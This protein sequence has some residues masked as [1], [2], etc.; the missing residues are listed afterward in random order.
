MLAL[1]AALPVLAAPPPSPP[2]LIVAISVDQFA[3]ALFRHYR[4]AY[5]GGLARLAGGIGFTGYQ[6]H[7]ATETCPGHST[8][9]TGDHPAHTG[10]VANEWFD[11]ATGSSIYCVSVPGTAD[12]GARGGQYLKVDTLGD[13]LKRARPGARVIAVSGKDRAAIMM[14][15]HH[16]DAIYWW[17]DRAGFTT[18]RY[19]APATP[20]VMEPARTFDTALFA[21][22]RA[23]PPALWPAEVPAR[24]VA[25][26]HPQSF[27]TLT[28]SGHVPPDGAKGIEAGDFLHSADFADQLRASPLFDAET[29]RFASDLIDHDRLGHGPATDLLAISLS[30]TDYIGHR[31]GNGGPEMCAQ[32]AAL[33]HALGIF[34]ARLDALGVPYV[35]VLTGDHGAE[36][37]TERAV[38]EGG[39]AQRIDGAAFVAALNRAVKA[40]VGLSYDP[41]MGGDP[42]QLLINVGPDPVL[43]GRVRDAAVAWLKAR[44]EVAAVFTADQVIAAAPPP[45]KPVTDLSL[46]ERFHESYY[47]GRSGDIAVAYR[48]GTTLFIPHRPGDI[49][50]THGSPWDYDRRVPILFWWPGAPEEQRHEPAETVDIAPTLAAIADIPAPPVDGHCLPQVA[51]CR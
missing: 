21:R 49:V 36:D 10:I 9:L 15:G 27:G 50:A 39:T 41:I 37:A 31:Y 28:L 51:A 44:P 42:Q 34:F 32:V 23:S 7:A 12:P 13:W 16:A 48:E 22:W 47:P 6:S 18:S 38:A 26:E 4:P 14:G 3:D 45:G 8:I 19:A 17:A 11:V 1:A 30:A 24:C 40:E 29:L 33:D 2:K 25:M 20:A 46:A 5:S 35:V 43:R